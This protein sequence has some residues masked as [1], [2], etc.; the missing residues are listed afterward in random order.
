MQKWIALFALVGAAVAKPQ[1]GG[2]PLGVGGVGGGAA[3]A[4]AA[5]AGN[6]GPIDSISENSCQVC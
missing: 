3:A 5:G 6:R 1:Y 2:A 4:A